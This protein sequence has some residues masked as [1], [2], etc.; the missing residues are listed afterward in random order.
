MLKNIEKAQLEVQTE[1]DELKA[2]QS[3]IQSN[4]LLQTM[5]DSRMKSLKCA[6]GKRSVL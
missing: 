1:A 5:K 3:Q 2:L 6:C 4:Y